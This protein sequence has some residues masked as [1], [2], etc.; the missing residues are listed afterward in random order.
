MKLPCGRTPKDSYLCCNR[1]HHW[2]NTY[3]MRT[4][5][6]WELRCL[7]CYHTIVIWNKEMDIVNYIF[8]NK[9]LNWED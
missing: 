4:P 6:G 1:R 2:W 9:T 5:I 8:K 3:W 7:F